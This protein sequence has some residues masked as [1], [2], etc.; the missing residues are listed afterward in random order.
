MLVSR[1]LRNAGYVGPAVRRAH[2]R[3]DRSRIARK[4]QNSRRAP[5]VESWRIVGVIQPPRI[6]AADV[7][8]DAPSPCAHSCATSDLAVRTLPRD[9]VRHMSKVQRIAVVGSG[10]SGLA[11]AW[12]L[13]RRHAVTLYEANDYLGGH[14]HTHKVVVGGRTHRVDTGFIVFN[15][16][17]YPL[18]TRLFAELG[19]PRSRP[20]EPVGA[21]RGER[22]RVQRQL[23]RDP[24]LSAAEPLVAAILSGSSATSCDS[25]ARRA[26]S[27]RLR[28]RVPPRASTSRST[29]RRCISRRTSGAH[30][31]RA[32]VGAAARGARISGP[33]SGAV[34]RE[35]RNV[36]SER[37]C[38]LARGAGRLRE[39]YPGAHRALERDGARVAR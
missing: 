8:S 37:P 26:R 32:V 1:R 29:L 30:E 39:V 24:V 15:P 38:A 10:I 14:T 19:V 13:A 5:G 36:A 7:A 25:T 28:A 9:G 11:S 23:A 4:G 16:A 18:L 31:L 6:R 12:L 35:P 27:C 34:P 20:H 17:H 3:G 2:P 22:P 33:L 21:Q